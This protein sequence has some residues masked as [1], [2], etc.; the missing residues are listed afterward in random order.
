MKIN[1]IKSYRI[2]TLLLLSFCVISQ[3]LAQDFE[4]GNY[5]DFAVDSVH[6]LKTNNSNRGSSDFFE[7]IF[8]GTSSNANDPTGTLNDV[9]SIDVATDTGSS[10]LSLNGVWGATADPENERMLFT[11]SSGLPPPSGQLGGGDNL[12]AVPYAGGAPVLLGRI[13]DGAGDGFRVDGLAMRNGVLYAAA[14][15][16][17]AANGLHTIDLQTF[18]ATEVALFADSISGIDAD[19]LSCVI[20]G[21]NDTTGQ[22]VT[23]GTDGVITDLIAYPAGIADIDGLAVG[24]GFAYLVTDESQEISV[25]NLT[26]LTY[27]TA[28]TSPFAMADTFSGAG[29]ALSAFGNNALD[30]IFLNG[31]EANSCADI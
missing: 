24:G 19:P 9:F 3:A 25:L 11:Q 21:T 22:V 8:A 26:T 10:I 6:Y 27:E 31:F 2:I 12:M 7:K 16:A 30:T 20:Y 13:V 17:G 29:I 15:T 5:A 1:I 28:L 18:L 4:E 23:L 14:A